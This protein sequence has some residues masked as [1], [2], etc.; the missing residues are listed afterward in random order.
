MITA[1]ALCAAVLTLGSSFT[2][3]PKNACKWA[4]LVIK[5]AD[6]HNIDPYIVMALIQVESNWN[7]NVVSSCN[8]CGLTQVLD[9]YSKYTCKQLKN[10]RVSIK[11]GLNK[12]NYWLNRYGKGDL[13]VGLCGYNAGHRCKGKKASTK[14][15]KYA[16]RVAIM[17]D[18][19]REKTRRNQ[20]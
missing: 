13:K 6:K 17:A 10:P 15:L 9:K 5:E 7:P 4:P 19:I 1:K 14:G 2:G 20:K 11:E 3:N 12:L 16:R 8:A 18:L